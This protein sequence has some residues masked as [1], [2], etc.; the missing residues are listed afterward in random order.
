MHQHKHISVVFKSFQLKNLV[1]ER[2]IRHGVI[3][4]HVTENSDFLRTNTKTK[5]SAA[6]SNVKL[7]ESCRILFTCLTLVNDLLR[8]D[9][10][11]E[12]DGLHEDARGVRA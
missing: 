6:A 11:R 5:I 7:G 2:P 4:S 1:T 8:G 9:G 10:G 3:R 12:V